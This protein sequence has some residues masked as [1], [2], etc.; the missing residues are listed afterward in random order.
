MSRSLLFH[1]LIKKSRSRL[2]H[3][4][5][6]VDISTFLKGLKC[7]DLDNIFLE[8]VKKMEIVEKKFQGA[9][10]WRSRLFLTYEK[11]EISTFL[12][13]FVGWQRQDITLYVAR[14]AK[15][16]LRPPSFWTWYGVWCSRFC[17]GTGFWGT[18]STKAPSIHAVALK[19]RTNSDCL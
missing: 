11:V 1:N 12:L 3:T 8:I 16:H 18:S 15:C 4:F 19:L 7:R 14:K 13:I 10:K 9:K 5:Q 17:S 2:F 6:K